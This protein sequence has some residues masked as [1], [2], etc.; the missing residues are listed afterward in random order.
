MRLVLKPILRKL[1]KILLNKQKINFL[2][3]LNI[4]PIQIESY[5][6][7]R[8]SRTGD[9]NLKKPYYL[10]NINILIAQYDSLFQ[11]PKF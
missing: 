10:L 6:E 9:L 4:Y 7:L 5:I 3:S 11:P 2:S 1:K 8:N